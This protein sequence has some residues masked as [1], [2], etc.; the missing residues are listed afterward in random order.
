MED[1]YI[2]IL[3]EWEE[4]VADPAVYEHIDVLFPEFSF[5][6]MQSGGEKDHWASRLKLDL[7]LPKRRNAEKTVIYRKEMRFREQGDWSGGSSVMDRIIKDQGLY[8]IFEAY[9]YV[10]SKL[11]LDMPKPDSKEVAEKLSRAQ[12][13]TAILDTLQDYF[14]WNL[15]NN[16]SQKAASAR[17][18][19]SKQRGFSPE[20]VSELGFGFVPDWSKVIRYIT[21]D[22]KFRLEELEEVCKVRNEDGGTTVG[23]KHVLSI[24]YRCGGVLKGFIFRIIDKGGDGPKY[25]ANIGL[26]RA[27]T[28][29]NIE[30]GR[31]LK[32][33]VVVEGEID[34]LKATAEGLPGVVA[35]GGAEISGERVKQVADAIERGVRKITLCLDLDA[36]KDDP[37]MPKT[38]ERFKKTMRSVHT[39]KDYKLDFEEIYVARFPSPSDPDEYIR[40]N[41]IRA[42]KK[43]IDDAVPYWK[44]LFEYMS[45]K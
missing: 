27:S 3:K 14:C 34:A 9:K 20:Q 24:P 36:G 40:N 10:A 37:A 6:R 11:G 17:Q 2:D 5:R 13:K 39:I 31:N 7:S 22:K 32:E 8:S 28:F 1:A 30:P 15:H 45:V 44:Y 25:F 19:L 35:I 33:I 29:F 26:D 42:F 18:Y 38:E 4:N 23:K 41:G 43:L 21:I 16:S 12:R